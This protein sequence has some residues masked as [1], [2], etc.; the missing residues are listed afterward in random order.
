MENTS[1][2]T[3]GVTSDRALGSTFN[4]LRAQFE[5]MRM[6]FE[7]KPVEPYINEISRL[8]LEM[9]TTAQA[10]K[11]LVSDQA[12]ASEAQIQRVRRLTD[13]LERQCKCYLSL[14]NLREQSMAAVSD[15]VAPPGGTGPLTSTNAT[16]T[17]QKGGVIGT[18]AIGGSV[19]AAVLGVA[20]QRMY[21]RRSPKRRREITRGVRENAGKA[22]AKLVSKLGLATL[23]DSGQ[24]QAEAVGVALGGALGNMGAELLGGLTKNKQIQK[25]GGEIGELIGEGVGG[26]IGK[27]FHGWFSQTGPN[28]LPGDS[29]VLTAQALSQQSPEQDPLPQGAAAAPREGIHGGVV[30]GGALVG[31]AALAMVGRKAHRAYSRLPRKRRK[32]LTGSI[33]KSAGKA[34]AKLMGNLGLALLE[35]NGEDQAEAIGTAFGGAMGNLGA[36][37]LGGLTKN[38]RIQQHG[39]EIGE[40]IGEGVGGFIGRT[41]HGVFSDTPAANDP[42]ATRA[43]D[44][45]IGRSAAGNARQVPEEWAPDENAE[46]LEEEEEEEEEGEEEAAFFKAQESASAAVQRGSPNLGRTT[47]GLAGKAGRGSLGA[48]LARR[49]FRRIPGVALLDTGLQ[50]AET[51]NSDATQEQKLEGYGTAVGGL[52]GGLAGAAA[53][54]AIG[55]VVP[56]IGTAIGGLIGGV[57][58]SMGGESI[59]GWLGRT[60]GA[61]KDGA[62]GKPAVGELN[63]SPAPPQSPAPPAAMSP[64]TPPATVNQQFTFTSN[65][66]VTF[67]NS[68][69]DPSVLQQLEMIARRQLEELMRQARPAQ[70][71]DPPHIVL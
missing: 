29:A 16:P 54:A 71:A 2:L 47:P 33:R 70:L 30:V 19:T 58:G 41:V 8:A 7:G 1:V 40:L 63:A 50:L 24:D 31:A 44:S 56:V 39:A 13:E 4:T 38:N 23:E 65:M 61:N 51:F 22:G 68:L 6:P 36:E 52:G 21:Q 3:V 69:D 15:T 20:A 34:S 45:A 66:P 57:L 11:R 48:S 17:V 18:A 64:T 46:Q 59:G 35:D 10:Q 60:L 9:D 37:L 32:K 12:W 28:D 43:S 25:H 27:T 55:S 62:A 67:N 5:R 49:A 42:P 26:F 14:A 53:G